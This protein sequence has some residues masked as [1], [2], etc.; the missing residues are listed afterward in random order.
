VARLF[1]KDEQ[2]IRNW[3]ARW[4]KER[5]VS[6]KPRPGRPSESNKL[7]EMIIKLVAYLTSTG[8]S[9]V[10]HLA[11]SYGKPV[12]ISRLQDIEATAR[13]EGYKL[14]F[15][16]KNNK[17]ELKNAIEKLLENKKLYLKIAKI[18]LEASERH[19][20]SKV[21]KMYVNLYTQLTSFKPG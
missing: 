3:I 4:K 1:C 21:A 13:E 20:F 15:V 8:T 9:G 17:R 19:S 10:V 2:T 6:N 11:V 18:N 14:V 16:K 12:I 5:S 7:E